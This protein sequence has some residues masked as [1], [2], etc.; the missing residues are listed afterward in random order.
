MTTS[1]RRSCWFLTTALAL[2]LSWLAGSAEAQGGKG[3]INTTTRM[4]YHD[5]PVMRGAVPVWVIF[6][7]CWDV[8]PVTNPPC[9][10][11][12]GQDDVDA[13][14]W[15]T[16]DVL[17]SSSYMAIN[18]TYPDSTGV[19]PLSIV[20]GGAVADRGYS[21]GNILTRADIE[22]IVAAQVTPPP[23]SWWSPLP[24]EPFAIYL[25][26]TSADV[27]VDYPA[28]FCS[29]YSEFHDTFTYSLPDQPGQVDLIYAFVGN[30]LRCPSRAAPQFTNPDGSLMPTPN[31]SFAADAMATSI[32]HVISGALTNPFGSAWFDRY[33]LENSDKCRGQFGDT[34]VTANGARANFT[35]AY[36]HRD[37]LIQQNW[38]NAD[39]GKGYCA[40]AYP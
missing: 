39:R 30:P 13:I 20:F 12:H 7:G 17:G 8:P 31:G 19:A 37:Y 3:K 33:G 38:V 27:S 11:G 14:I 4:I 23:G 40:L 25:V 32:A 5:G 29:S 6:Y 15:A 24:L 10:S 26:L 36:S 9:G 28:G 22:Q 34:Y 21:R 1:M 16:V 35:G 18:S 2:T